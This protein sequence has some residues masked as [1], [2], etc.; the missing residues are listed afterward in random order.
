MRIDTVLFF[1][2]FLFAPSTEYVNTPSLPKLLLCIPYTDAYN[3]SVRTPI[4][5]VGFGRVLDFAWSFR[6]YFYNNVRVFRTH[7]VSR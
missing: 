2:H 4:T 6:A 3:P 1:L 5:N 7:G